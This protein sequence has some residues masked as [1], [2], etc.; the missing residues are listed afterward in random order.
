MSVLGDITLI[1]GLP[2]CDFDPIWNKNATKWIGHSLHPLKI[3]S[4]SYIASS[5]S[6]QQKVLASQRRAMGACLSLCIPSSGS[7]EHN[8]HDSE[9]T[10]LLQDPS[11]ILHQPPRHQQLSSSSGG[12]GASVESPDE[13][14]LERILA[15]TSA[16]LIDI[17]AT[18]DGA[19]KPRLQYLIDRLQMKPSQES[20]IIHQPIDGNGEDDD[21]HDHANHIDGAAGNAEVVTTP[22][23]YSTLHKIVMKPSKDLITADEAKFLDDTVTQMKQVL[24]EVT[25][26]KKVDDVIVKLR[27][28]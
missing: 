5:N 21:D 19:S 8:L 22:K 9:H 4:H 20:I 27:W 16:G 6:G 15:Q 18:H 2:L 12:G 17:K 24:D 26:R 7:N 14:Q 25:T 23:T 1:C 3:R 13:A 10:P 11:L 28:D